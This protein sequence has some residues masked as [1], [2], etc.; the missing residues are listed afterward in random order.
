MREDR[1]YE[2]SPQLHSLIAEH[3]WVEIQYVDEDFGPGTK[4]LGA[5]HWLALHRNRWREHDL[6]MILDDDHA[7]L[8]N[9][10]E[11]LAHAQLAHGPQWAVSFFAYFFRGIMV[12]QGADVI[13]LQLS[14]ALVEDLTEYHRTFVW[15]DRACFLVDDLWI[16]VFLWLSGRRVASL[17]ELVTGRGLETVYR[18]TKN[19]SVLALEALGGEDRRDRATLRAF[20]GLL[21]RL[22]SAGPK[23]LQ[24]WG[25][26]DAAQRV[27]QLAA[28]VCGAE[29]RIAEL[30]CLLGPEQGTELAAQARRQAEQQLAR[31]VHLY[32]MQRPPPAPAEAS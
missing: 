9:A 26:A 11:E 32:R 13:S 6:L 28:E 24:R 31:L 16:G 19:A 23:G 21:A 10:L 12:P 25:G 30:E 5:L 18:R 2:L 15:G 20:D 8:P 29:Q 14:E 22:L 3:P 7:Y 4:L 17:R 1:Q 27:Q